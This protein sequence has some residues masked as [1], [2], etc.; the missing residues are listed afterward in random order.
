MCPPC[1]LIVLP[2]GLSGHNYLWDYLG[3]I[4]QCV[5]TLHFICFT[6]GV[7]WARF[8]NV[9]LLLADEAA[10]KVVGVLPGPLR[11]ALLR[12]VLQGSTFEAYA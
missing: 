10:G 12:G 7:I 11:L 2:L 4:W 5:S 6:S 9:P 3:K 1:S 8:G